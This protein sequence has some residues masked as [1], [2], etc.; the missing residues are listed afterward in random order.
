MKLLTTLLTILT[1]TCLIAGPIFFVL[2]VMAFV[3]SGRLGPL[4]VA[5]FEALMWLILF[6]TY[7][8]ARRAGVA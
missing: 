3:V 5:L 7:R 4:G 6:V 1:L 8:R 2:N